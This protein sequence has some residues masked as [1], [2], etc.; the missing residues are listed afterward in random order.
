MPGISRFN[1]FATH[2]GRSATTT[3]ASRG[4]LNQVRDKFVQLFSRSHCQLPSQ[5]PTN[6]HLSRTGQ[7]NL[8]SEQTSAM[9]AECAA[10]A[11]LR[12]EQVAESEYPLQAYLQQRAVLGERVEGA[13]LT[14]LRAAH[15][16]VTETRDLL[17]L[18]RGNV[19]DDI[20][21]S[22]NRSYEHLLGF[23]TYAGQHGLDTK[24]YAAAAVKFQAGNCGEF[25]DVATHIHSGK[26]QPEL[27]VS[28]VASKAV[29]HSWSE[30]SPKS[31]QAPLNDII[32]DA[33]AE[34]P[35]ILRQDARFAAY[36]ENISTQYRY[37]DAKGFNR[38]QAAQSRLKVSVEKRSAAYK[39]QKIDPSH[40][41]HPT[42][43][44]S[45]AFTELARQRE[46]AIATGQTLSEKSRMLRQMGV[47][48]HAVRKDQ[49]KQQGKVNL[50]ILQAGVTR[51]L[52]LKPAAPQLQNPAGTSESKDA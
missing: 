42:Q 28:K 36:P 4:P 13:L 11:D 7:R 15:A 43:V 47:S 45:Q 31:G 49:V 32:L 19:T 44:R 12:Q 9:P 23:R 2:C 52:R 40:C 48:K 33:W 26:L 25:A 41:W 17:A 6:I 16:S 29:D 34:G 38:F 35:A 20:N 39:G 18:G 3:A 46:T 5:Q 50:E 30:E 22:D 37:Q 24:S 27:Q 21:A 14:R 1:P 51:D 10:L 8:I